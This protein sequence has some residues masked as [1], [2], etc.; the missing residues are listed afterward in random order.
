MGHVAPLEKL[1]KSLQKMAVIALTFGALIL[2]G[3]SSSPF[4]GPAD[5]VTIV[6]DGYSCQASGR[7]VSSC[8]RHNIYSNESRRGEAYGPDAAVKKAEALAC[9]KVPEHPNCK[10]Q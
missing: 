10:K 9:I 3:C 5:N 8:P 2:A 1:M 6:A 7:G 4:P